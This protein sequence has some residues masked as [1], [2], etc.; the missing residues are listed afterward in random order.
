MDVVLLGELPDSLAT[1]GRRGH[2]GMMSDW[3]SVEDILLYRSG[4]GWLDPWLADGPIPS[5]VT[6]WQPLPDPPEAQ[7]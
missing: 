7:Q 2:G 5:E 6:H 4:I 3:I 1:T